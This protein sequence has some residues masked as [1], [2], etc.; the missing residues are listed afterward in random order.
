MNTPGDLLSVQYIEKA[1][2]CHRLPLRICRLEQDRN[3]LHSLSCACSDRMVE[4]LL[5]PLQSCHCFYKNRP[6]VKGCCV[7]HKL[8]GCSLNLHALTILG[9]LDSFIMLCT[10]KDYSELKYN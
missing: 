10:K 1:M 2:C 7:I 5:C 3:Q 9:V 4:L 6:V 8:E